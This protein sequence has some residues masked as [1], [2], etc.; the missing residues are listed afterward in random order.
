MQ[1]R[2]C[3]LFSHTHLPC[4]AAKHEHIKFYSRFLDGL[5]ELVRR[6]VFVALKSIPSF[7]QNECSKKSTRIRK[8]INSF[9]D[10]V[11]N[12]NWNKTNDTDIDND[13][14]QQQSNRCTEDLSTGCNKYIAFPLV[15]SV[16]KQIF[17]TAAAVAV[18]L[19]ENILHTY[20]SIITRIQTLSLTHSLA[21]KSTKKSVY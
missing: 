6:R 1:I 11:Q 17:T 5:C 2:V 18:N 20:S 19:N 3:A 13:Q 21:P 14:W 10:L 4:L 16:P 9:Y 7:K 8:F 12:S 15:T